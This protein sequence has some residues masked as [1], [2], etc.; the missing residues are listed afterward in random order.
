MAQSEL[1][2]QNLKEIKKVT[3]SIGTVFRNT[4]TDINKNMSGW[5][6]GDRNFDFNRDKRQYDYVLRIKQVGMKIGG[7]WQRS[8]TLEIGEPMIDQIDALDLFRDMVSDYHFGSSGRCTESMSS[9]GHWG[10]DRRHEVYNLVF[11]NI[12]G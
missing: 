8:R 6:T 4:R 7:D 9:T 10:I 2:K 5:G 1:F 12:K 3:K 11:F